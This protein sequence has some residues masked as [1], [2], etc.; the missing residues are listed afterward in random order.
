MSMVIPNEGETQLLNDL[1]A[2]GT[3]EN[4]S[5]RLYSNNITPAETDTASTYTEATFTGYSAKTLTRSVT[6]T[7]W[8]TPTQTGTTLES[9][10]AKSTYGSS[11]QSWNATSAQTIYGYYLVGATSTK[12]IAAEKFA[13]SIGLV[14]PS[15]LTM[16]PAME[17]A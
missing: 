1:L 14:N 13:S 8:A 17:L 3:L 11:A 9:S 5:L 7:T 12:L 16:T 15:T 4:W 6:G 10:N 2:G